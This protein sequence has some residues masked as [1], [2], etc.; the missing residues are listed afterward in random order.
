MK[1]LS[2]E[3][4]YYQRNNVRNNH[5]TFQSLHEQ[6]IIESFP[7]KFIIFKTS[8]L[9][10]NQRLQILQK[11]RFLISRSKKKNHSL[12]PPFLPTTIATKTIN[13]IS[14]SLFFCFI[15]LKI[16][17]TLP[18]RVGEQEQ[19]IVS[20]ERTTDVTEAPSR[21]VDSSFSTLLYFIFFFKFF[22]IWQKE[23]KYRWITLRRELTRK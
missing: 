23:R 16:R 15:S 3:W 4:M 12:A 10:F 21:T 9:F 8:K 1:D 5:L 7:V 14:F 22:S 6:I 11:I 18:R 17:L 13:S 2:S 20:L 19:K